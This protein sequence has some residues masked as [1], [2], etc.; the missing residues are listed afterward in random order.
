MT[1]DPDVAVAL[2][3]IQRRDGRRFKHVLNDVLRA[4]IDSLSTSRPVAHG[5]S[6]TVPWDGGAP[7]IDL[8]STSAA[9]ENAEG[10]ERS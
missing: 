2:E 9:L 5:G 10:H 7:L 1:I 8:S 4:G 3:Q 6:S